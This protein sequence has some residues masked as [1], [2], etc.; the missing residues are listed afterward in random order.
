MIADPISDFI[1]R[2][3]NASRAGR[4]SVTLPTSKMKAAIAAVLERE[5]YLSDVEVSPREPKLTV[6]LAYKNGRPAISGV[7]RISK[8]SRRLYMGVR[9]IHPVKRGHG[10]VL[11]STP[12][13]ILT[14]KEAGEARVGGEILFEIW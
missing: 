6:S 14:G 5:G 2:L 4:S 9:D 13:G 12:K 3:Q 8:P 1:V 7:K 10:L 11:L